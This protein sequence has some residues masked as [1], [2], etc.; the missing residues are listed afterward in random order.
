MK[1]ILVILSILFSFCASA[2]TTASQPIQLGEKLP[3]MT[4]RNLNGPDSLVHVNWKN[5]LTILDF[6]NTRCVGT[7]GHIPNLE[8]IINHFGSQLQVILVSKD[9]EKS[10]M[11]FLKQN[12]ALFPAVPVVLADSSIAKKM[13]PFITAPQIWVDEHSV[14]Q[15]IT[16]SWNLNEKT[17]QKILDGKRLPLSKLNLSQ[18]IMT[19]K[20]VFTFD[21]SL[22]LSSLSYFS[23]IGHCIDGLD[24]GKRVV[25]TNGRPDHP[26]RI[27]FDCSP[28]IDLFRL[29]FSESSKYD[30]RPRNTIVFGGLDTT[31]FIKPHQDS[32]IFDQWRQQNL[33]TYDLMVPEERSEQLYSTMQQDLCRFFN[34]QAKIEKRKIPCYVLTENG[35][36]FKNLDQPLES[37]RVFREGSF[38]HYRNV[39]LPRAWENFSSLFNSKKIE[40]PLIDGTT[41]KGQVD[42]KFPQ[43]LYQ[44]F[45]VEGLNAYLSPY[46]LKIIEQPRLVSVLVIR[47]LEKKRE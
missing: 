11:A 1:S 29:A 36:K 38:I 42:F 45:S 24:I 39:T 13:A 12:K 32:E 8:A 35:S 17:I 14:I 9:D 22:Y 30:L 3:P 41:Y 21:T 10:T 43:S 20:P 33:F 16:G 5:K 46:G 44:S 37:P 31:S 40:K 18:H 15:Y 26:N 2:Q 19:D 4:F 23:Y 27:T 6:W 34:V 25:N 28:P 47:P 7:Y